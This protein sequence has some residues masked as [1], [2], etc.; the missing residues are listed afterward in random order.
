MSHT[1]QTRRELPGI[2]S[3]KYTEKAIYITSEQVAN[4]PPKSRFLVPASFKLCESC[5]LGT[6][7]LVPNHGESKY[8]Q[9]SGLVGWRWAQHSPTP[10]GLCTPRLLLFNVCRGSAH[11]PV[12]PGV[13]VPFFIINCT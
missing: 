3:V 8:S 6:T 2:L 11:V 5:A 1:H 13:T 12:T 7:L 4:S 9:G 10:S